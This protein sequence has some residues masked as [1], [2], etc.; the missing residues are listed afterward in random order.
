[1]A[2]TKKTFPVLYKYTQKGQIQQ[3]Q[4]IAR[5]DEFWTIEGIKDGK[6]TT[7]LPTK[8]SGKNLGKKNATTDEE[9]AILEAQAKWQKKKDNSYNEVLTKKRNFFE[10]MLAQSYKDYPIDWKNKTYKVF[11]QP[12]LDGLRCVNEDSTL[13]SR[14]GKPYVACP[15]LLQ[16]GTTLDG[17]LYTHE[18]KDDFNK[19]VS[20]CKKQKP[21]D[22]ELEESAKKVE[23]WAY[24]MP[25]NAIFSLRYKAL[26][27]WV[28]GQDNKMIRLVPTFEIHSEEDLI[29]WHAKFIEDGYEGTIVRTDTEKYENKRSK[30]LLKYKD[31]ID[32][33][34][35]IVGYEEGE[36]GRVGTIGKFWVRLDKKKPF[37]IEK[38]E[39]VCKSNVKGNFD[40]LRQVWKDRKIYIGTEATIKFFGY[41][42]DKALRFPYV[43]KLNRKEYE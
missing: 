9:Q 22:E 43:I 13:M 18:Y 28:L 8:C 34:F 31:F 16:Y 32:E 20:L 29:E 17:E 33:E 15:H 39:N 24:D 6:L 10:P 21:T 2:T 35:E 5:G 1:M 40:F 11:V 23:F 4:I 38:K 27:K 14:N 3:W 30:Q 26:E 41:T 12:K 42:P 36:G 37:S 7:S 25:M 19:I